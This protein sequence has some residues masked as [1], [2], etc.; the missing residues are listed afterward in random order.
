MILTAHQPVYLPWIG[1]FHKIYLADQ[2]CWF[3]IAQYQKRDFN[4][5]NK[6]KT[7]QGELWLTVPVESKDHFEKKLSE[8]KI[9]NNGWNKKQFKSICLSYKKAKYFDDYISSFETIL[10]NNEYNLLSDLCFDILKYML[11]CFSIQVPIVKASD[12]DF[13]GSKSD[14]V[15]DMCVKLQADKY[16]FGALGKDYADVS[17]FNSKGIQVYF[18]DY[19]HPVYSQLHGNFLPYMSAIDL[20][21]NEGMRSKEVMLENNVQSIK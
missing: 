9:I 21:F 11:Q 6:I 10:I 7:S 4:N 15:L 2:F 16:I 1:L 5:R 18:Q 12:Y 17:S 8:I 19:K 20:L 13:A 14:L 3:D